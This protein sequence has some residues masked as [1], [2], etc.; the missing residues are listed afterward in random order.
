MDI[1]IQ[2]SIR[3]KKREQNDVARQFFGAGYGGF[4]LSKKYRCELCGEEIE[5]PS[6]RLAA[7]YHRHKHPEFEE[8][9]RKAGLL[10]LWEAEG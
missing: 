7:L 1:F 2:E 6:P 10:E 8:A 5:A 9:F 4:G 3:L